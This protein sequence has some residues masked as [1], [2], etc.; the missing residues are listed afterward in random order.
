MQMGGDQTERPKEGGL[1]GKTP[2]TGR[3]VQ[4]G[5]R[6]L[7]LGKNWTEKGG[8]FVMDTSKILRE[9]YAK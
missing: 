9:R 5:F 6:T 7:E 3:A 4:E 1:I 8:D 2:S